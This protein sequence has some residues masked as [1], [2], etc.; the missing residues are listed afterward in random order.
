M[1]DPLSSGMREENNEEGLQ[2]PGRVEE[3]GEEPQSVQSLPAVGLHSAEP[4]GVTIIV[5]VTSERDAN[6]RVS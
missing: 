2:T 4:Q 1:R 6:T 3:V 5:C